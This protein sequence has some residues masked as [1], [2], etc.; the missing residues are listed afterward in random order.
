VY[1]RLKAHFQFQNEKKLFPIGNQFKFSINVFSK[2]NESIGFL[3][4]SN[5][6]IP[7]TID[8]CFDHIGESTV[9]GIKDDQD[10]WS[11]LGHKNRI[12]P[13]NVSSLSIFSELF[14]EVGTFPINARLPSI[15]SIELLKVLERLSEWPKRLSD[16]S[17]KTF[18]SQLWNEVNAQEDNFIKRKTKFVDECENWVMSGPHFYVGNPFHQTPREICETHR[19]YDKIDLNDLPDNYLPRSNYVPDT[20]P[21]TFQKG[22]PY[23][24]WLETGEKSPRKATQYYRHINREMIA[25]TLERTLVSAIIPKHVSHINTCLSTCFKDTSDLLAYHVMCLSVVVDYRVKSTGMGHANTS[26]IN[27][28]PVL[29]SEK[30]ALRAGLFVRALGLSCLSSQYDELWQ[31]CWDELFTSQQWSSDISLLNQDYFKNI[32][33]EW[34]WQSALRTDFERRQALLEIDVLVAQVMGLTLQELLTIYR[35]QFPVMQQY[36]RETYYDQSGCIVFTPSKG[37]VGVGLSRKVGKKDPSV[38]IEYPD[39]TTESKP[40]GWEDAQH[41]PD[42]TKILRTIEDDTLPSGK[43][44]K[45]ITYTAPWH[46]PSREDD[47]RQAWQ[48][49]SERLGE[50]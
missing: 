3:N 29:V 22:V 18:S 45:V 4:I 31:D 42:G 43:R 9:P 36:E 41:L 33:D 14:D 12:V 15:H 39:G 11:I 6:F 26:L 30:P 48:V 38:I 10:S 32:T 16:L 50:Q 28:L 24:S 8:F 5:L 23:V 44:E 13:I 37:L 1:K 20:D 35:V 2:A 17:D 46:L 47:Y 7:R 34:S 21:H 19:A 49:F 27:Q 25:S 40:L